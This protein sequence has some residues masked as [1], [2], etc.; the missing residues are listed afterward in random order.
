MVES[1]AGELQA[2]R[3]IFSFE[4]GQFFKDLLLREA[5]SKKIQ[6]VT[7][8]NSHPANAR[9]SSALCRIDRDALDEFGHDGYF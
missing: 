2:G 5:C 9:T 8:S 7:D 3:N 4:I 6:H 1:A